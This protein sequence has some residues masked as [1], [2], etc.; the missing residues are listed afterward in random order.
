MR[1]GD[2]I[3]TWVSEDGLSAPRMNRNIPRDRL[4][5]YM[6]NSRVAT[7]ATPLTHTLDSAVHTEYVLI[8]HLPEIMVKLMIPRTTS[9]TRDRAHLQ[10]QDA[11]SFSDPKQTDNAKHEALTLQR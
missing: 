8:S 4:R 3:Y 11:I 10:V 5:P 7:N 9:K 1:C 6:A 2:N